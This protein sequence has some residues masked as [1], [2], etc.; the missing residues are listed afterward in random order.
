MSLGL[1]LI[2]KAGRKFGSKRSGNSG[3]LFV[4]WIT[5]EAKQALMSYLEERERLGEKVTKDSPLFTD[6]YNKG[7]F[8]T[9]DAY[10]RVWARLLHR[11]GLS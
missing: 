11:V 10:G 8:I 9:I 7:T 6:A 2:R 5:P 3:S 4:S 1:L